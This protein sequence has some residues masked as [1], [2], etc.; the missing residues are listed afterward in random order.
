[1]LPAWQGDSNT[2][3]EQVKGVEMVLDV[4][5]CG[6]VQRGKLLWC[7]HLQSALQ[8]VK[9]G[10]SLFT[11]SFTWALKT[12]DLS[13][14]FNIQSESA[15]LTYLLPPLTLIFLS[16]MWRICVSGS[17]V[18]V[19]SYLSVVL[20]WK[21]FRSTAS[22]CLCCLSTLSASFQPPWSSATPAQEVALSCTWTGVFVSLTASV[23]GSS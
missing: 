21:I 10:S 5:S 22:M 13:S 16:A 6:E 19:N 17:Q 20:F 4:W 11:S 9:K 7:S 8:R 14:L 3:S 23:S 18:S 2:T 15:L 1:M 12:G